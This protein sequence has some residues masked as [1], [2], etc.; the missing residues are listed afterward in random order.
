MYARYIPAPHLK[1]AYKC[2]HIR[3]YPEGTTEP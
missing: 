1:D 3:Q 2:G